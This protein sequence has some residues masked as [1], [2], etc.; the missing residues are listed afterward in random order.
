MEHVEV[1]AEVCVCTEMDGYMHPALSWCMCMYMHMYMWLRLYMEK[2][3]CVEGACVKSTSDILLIQIVVPSSP[4]VRA[5]RPSM[6][7]DARQLPSMSPQALERAL[8]WCSGRCL[9]G[10]AF[11]V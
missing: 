7:L 8:C 3:Q 6:H 5:G 10:D 4:N 11:S 9:V 2:T 1:F